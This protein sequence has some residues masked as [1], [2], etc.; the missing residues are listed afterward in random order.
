M[1]HHA[2]SHSPLSH[3]LS[4]EV[5]V[6]HSLYLCGLRLPDST[7]GKDHPADEDTEAQGRGG[8]GRGLTRSRSRAGSEALSLSPAPGGQFHVKWV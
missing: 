3:S 8:Q 7:N 5:E 6:G 2:L 4:E 1:K